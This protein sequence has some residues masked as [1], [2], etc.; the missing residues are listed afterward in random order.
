MLEPSPVNPFILGSKDP[1]EKN[2]KQLSYNKSPFSNLK[3]I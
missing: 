1:E 2:K 3:V